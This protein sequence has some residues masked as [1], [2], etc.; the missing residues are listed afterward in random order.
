[1]RRDTVIEDV[2]R[3]RKLANRDPHTGLYHR[4][5]FVA[6]VEAAFPLLYAN[7]DRE[8]GLLYLAI[9]N[10][11]E[12]RDTHG[13]DVAEQILREIAEVLDAHKPEDALLARF[14]DYSFAMLVQVPA[15]EEFRKLAES[16]RQA[17]RNHSFSSIEKF[18]VASLSIGIVPSRRER[19]PSAQDFINRA[20]RTYQEARGDGGNRIAEYEPDAATTAATE[21]SDAALIEMVDFAI[22]HDRFT[23]GFQPILA[24]KKHEYDNYEIHLYLRDVDD[25]ELPAAVFL[26]PAQQSKRLEEID[27]W[28]I[29][30][31]LA[32]I[33]R[34]PKSSR[35]L[36]FHVP[37]S[38]AALED[39]RLVSWLRDA[40]EKNQVKPAQLTLLLANEDV[41]QH[42]QRARLIVTA[43]A[44]LGCGVMIRS[45]GKSAEDLALLKQLPG[46]SGV[47]LDDNLSS[48]AGPADN[49]SL[50]N[51]FRDINQSFQQMDLETLVGQ[52]THANKVAALWSLGVD[53]IKGD[54]LSG[55]LPGPVFDFAQY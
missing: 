6:G 44:K 33:S 42:L 14:G 36:H 52:A 3:L 25:R 49:A 29:T 35:P 38:P 28:V 48:G 23:L 27:R 55:P 13:L 47:H 34:P 53:Y 8:Y 1:M 19:I 45:V 40:L 20:Y 32:A 50:P 16:L 5:Y 2:E 41:R 46:I 39:G 54:F 4:N 18:F 11:A 17:V 51:D 43:L 22:A 15:A 12:I 7:E 24:T 9:D 31:C 30:K 37:L 21:T 26:K 10:F